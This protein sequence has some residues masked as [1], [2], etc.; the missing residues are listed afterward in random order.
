MP[1]KKQAVLSAVFSA[2]A[3]YEKNLNGNNLLFV[4]LDKHKNTSY[5]E[6]EFDSSNFMHLTG[7]QFTNTYKKSLK[8]NAD[9]YGNDIEISYANKFYEKCINRKMGINEFEFSENGT[10]QL[11]L[12]VLPF[13]MKSNLSAN[14]VGK[15][16]SL[17]CKLYT[18]RVAGNVRGCMG[19]VKDKKV[20]KNVPNTVLKTDI[21][22]CTSETKRI[23]ATFRKK[24]AEIAYRENVYM[25]KNVDFE[26]IKFPKEIN[27]LKTLITDI[28]DKTEN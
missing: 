28:T 10:T 15:F 4:L 20:N 9:N 24:K 13:L 7:I 16:T 18:E 26:E 27:Y 11:K 5:F 25:A 19:F 14:M 12:Q 23:I 21:R 3:D 17:T 8:F 22:D 6:V 2:A 1:D